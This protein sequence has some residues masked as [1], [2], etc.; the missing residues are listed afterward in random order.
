MKHEEFITIAQN[1]GDY[2]WYK[3]LHC[4]VVSNIRNYFAST[5]IRIIDAACGTGGLLCFLK[6]RGYEN[7]S[8]FDIADEAVKYS[9]ERNLDVFKG[10][11]N[12]VEEYYSKASADVIICNDALYFLDEAA[13]R[14]AIS[15]L[16]MILKPNGI[17][18]INIPALGAF[19]GIHDLQVSINTRVNRS[20]FISLFNPLTFHLESVRYWPFVLSPAIWV[21]R[22]IQRF[23]LKY[24]NGFTVKSDVR[25]LSPLL[26]TLLFRLVKW[27]TTRLSFTPFG[28]SL[29]VVLKKKA[30]SL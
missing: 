3:A 5:G 8:G 7:T 30:N 1:E 16:G 17:L 12:T 20:D 13:Q 21:V 6:Y 27:E 4:L 28:S 23:R 9:K 11:I 25:S 26:N 10:D 22:A 14:K 18:M 19:R 29:F 15:S 24:V 2:W